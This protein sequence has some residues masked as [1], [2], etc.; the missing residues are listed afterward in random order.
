MMGKS[1]NYAYPQ[2]FEE[3]GAVKMTDVSG[4][5]KRVVG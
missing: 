2:R 4:G 5:R 3:G 1:L